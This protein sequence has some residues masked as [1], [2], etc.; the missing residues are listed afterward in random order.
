MNQGTVLRIERISPSDGQGLRTVVY[1]KGCPL[2]C[3][4]CSTPESQSSQPEWFYKQAK[5]QQCAACIMACPQSA[6]SFSESAVIRDKSKCINCFKCASACLSHAIGI[7]GKTMTV[8]QVMREIRKDTLFYFYSE[9][10][11][12]LSGGDVL[13][14]ADFARE[15]LKACQEDCISTTAELDMYGSYKNV[16]KVLEYLDSYFVDIK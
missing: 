9:G 13:V 11:V 15:I 12:T 14:Q 7:Y 8:D 5:C 6:L 10:G 2:R 3:A 1:F 4:W 16:K